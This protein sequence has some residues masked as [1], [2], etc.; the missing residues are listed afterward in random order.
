MPDFEAKTVCL[1]GRQ[2]ALGLAELE[3]VYG[4]EHVKAGP[5]GSALLD[6]DA[7][8]INFKNLG[9]TIKVARLLDTISSNQWPD[10]LRYL[11]DKVPQRLN[12]APGGKFTLGASLYGFDVSPAK[13]NRDLLGLKKVIKDS[14]RS[15]RLVPNKKPELSSAQVL[16]NKLTR[17]GAS[18]LLLIKDGYQTLFAQ[19]IFVQDIEAYAARDQVRPARDARVGMLPPKLAQIIINLSKPVARSKQQVAIILDPFCGTGVI[20]Q[21]ALLMG[22]GVIGSDTEPRMIDF[23]KKNLDWLSERN[24]QLATRYSLFQ[25][26]AT[27][28]KWPD[29]DTLASEVYLG[30]PLAKIP[31]SS[32]LKQIISDVDT[33]I[34]KFLINLAP[35]LET[36]QRICLAVPAWIDAK[37]RTSHTIHLPL[38]AKLT[39]MGYNRYDFV[40]VRRDDLVYFREGQ[41]VARELLVLTRI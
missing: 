16:H 25:A 8:E 7:F 23:S 10:C 33:I 26:D 3:S 41:I 36:G 24:S 39:D 9:G 40:H 27:T 14:G 18:E 13:L 35:Q 22:Y 11:K 38:L 31:S 30:R 2:P 21:E 20:L 28:H 6:I 15:V 17:L 29:F 19:T 4:A 37:G 34:R 32:E 1:L 12:L 5:R